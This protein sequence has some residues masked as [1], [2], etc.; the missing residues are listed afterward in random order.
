MDIYHNWLFAFPSVFFSGFPLRLLSH[1][2]STLT[3]ATSLL[4]VLVLSTLAPALWAR[5]SALPPG[6]KVLYDPKHSKAALPVPK[7]AGVVKTV[8]E[9]K[10]AGWN[11]AARGDPLPAVTPGYKASQQLCVA[12]A[13]P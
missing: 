6:R 3:S 9:R 8:K 5:A 11:T 10:Q 1:S 13:V 7:A 4:E 2:S 12:L